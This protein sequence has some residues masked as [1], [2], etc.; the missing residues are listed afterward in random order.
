MLADLP[1]EA[2]STGAAPGICVIIAILFRGECKP[3]TVREV[4][5]L[6]KIFFQA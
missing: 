4:D 5:N 2:N 1:V 6:G 3:H